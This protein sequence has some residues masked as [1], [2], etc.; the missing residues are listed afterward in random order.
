M[1]RQMAVGFCGA[2]LPQRIVEGGGWRVSWL[3][4]WMDGWM[5]GCS[6]D[7][8]DPTPAKTRTA[9]ISTGCRGEE[10][11]GGGISHRAQARAEGPIHQLAHERGG[12]REW[13]IPGE[14]DH[15]PR[16]QTCRTEVETTDKQIQKETA[17]LRLG[18]RAGGR[19]PQLLLSYVGAVSIYCGCI[20]I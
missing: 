13:R 5:D 15:L 1:D 14:E 18:P 9:S 12:S 6:R 3:V 7:V 2:R 8:D 19:A 20:S 17:R 11:G 10:R 16:R 4:G